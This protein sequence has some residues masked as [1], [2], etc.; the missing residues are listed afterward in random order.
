[1]KQLAQRA[2]V[3]LEQLAQAVERPGLTGERARSAVRN[4]L[5]GRD[6]P[7]CKAGDL[8]KLA[9]A[10]GV[11]PKDIARFTSTVRFHRGSPRKAKLLVDL[12]RG[13][14]VDEAET[15]LRFSRQRAATNVRKALMAAYAD[16]QVADADAAR[17]VVCESRVDDGPRLKR[18]QP[19]DRGRAHL[20]L[21]RFAHITVS[22]EERPPGVG[23]S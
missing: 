21:K 1:M 20:I 5:Q 19:K 4:W 17:L 3:S 9:A 14:K 23:A 6:H 18:F 22:V 11:A 12:I 7:R 15:I 2:G 10:V 8:A 16:A 13:R